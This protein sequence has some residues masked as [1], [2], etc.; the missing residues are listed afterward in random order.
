MTSFEVF[1]H[2][3]KDVRIARILVN[4]EIPENVVQDDPGKLQDWIEAALRLENFPHT[5]STA[6]KRLAK[7][8]FLDRAGGKGAG[9]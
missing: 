5:I 2:P 7:A 1:F 3:S 4:L 9:A 6:A 8:I